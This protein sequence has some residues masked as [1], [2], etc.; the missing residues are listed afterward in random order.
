MYV[1]PD[2]ILL[3]AARMVHAVKWQIIGQTTRIKFLAQDS[4][5]L[6]TNLG[7]TNLHIQ[8]ISHGPCPH[9]C[10]TYYSNERG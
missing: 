3:Q 10:Q 1:V 9:S 4:I 5:F 8:W 7:I 6:F 2:D